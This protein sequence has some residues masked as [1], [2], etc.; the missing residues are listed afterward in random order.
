MSTCIDANGSDG[1]SEECGLVR[2]WDST[3]LAQGDQT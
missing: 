2:R 1:K 3:L